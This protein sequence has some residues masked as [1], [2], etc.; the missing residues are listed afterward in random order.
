MLNTISSI[1][2]IQRKNPSQIL[3]K[4][5][6]Y[7]LN[8]EHPKTEYFAFTNKSPSLRSVDHQSTQSN[9]DHALDDN[10]QTRKIL[11]SS[12]TLSHITVIDDHHSTTKNEYPCSLTQMLLAYA[13]QD[14]EILTSLAPKRSDNSLNNIL[15]VLELH[16]NMYTN[17]K[18]EIYF[19]GIFQILHDFKEQITELT[20]IETMQLLQIDPFASCNFENFILILC[21]LPPIKQDPNNFFITFNELDYNK[22]LYITFEDIQYVLSHLTSRFDEEIIRAAIHTIDIDHDQDRLSY[23]DFVTN[24]TVPCSIPSF[25][26]SGVIVAGT[27]S[28]GS[29]P[30]QLNL[31]YGLYVGLNDSVYVGDVGN[32][33]IQLWL[34]GAIQGI[35]VAGGQGYGSNA[36]QLDGARDVYVDSAYNLIVLDT[37][38][39]RIQQYNLLSGSTIG[40]TIMSNLPLSCRNMFV[41]ST[42]GTIYLSDM[43]NHN[44]RRMPNGTILAGGNG[45]GSQSNQLYYP[46]GLFV[47]PTGTIYVADS[48]ND[49]VQMW[50][51]G[52]SIGIT[53]AGGNGRGSAANQLNSP[54]HVIYM[55]STGNLIVTDS[56]NGRIQIW[57]PNA[58]CGI[59]IVSNQFMYPMSSAL[60]L[61]GQNLYVLDQVRGQVKRFNLLSSN[62]LCIPA[63][64]SIIAPSTTTA[65]TMV[66]SSISSTVSGT[67]ALTT[68]QVDGV[69]PSWGIVVITVGTVGL[70]VIASF[71]YVLKAII[72]SQTKVE[73]FV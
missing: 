39:R 19:E 55:A 37:G 22:D 43:Y 3:F 18:Q 57:A 32:D 59:T 69:I 71:I 54:M 63:N 72:T 21:H 36:T 66:A 10:D 41:E 70:V 40:T 17:D 30:Q 12:S 9:S 46:A 15:N 48:F 28:T 11:N 26:P 60:D 56:G 13:Q 16:F 67:Q 34:S 14:I 7:Q 25:Y 38:N 45:F 20:L 58:T 52:A 35:T 2:N 68:E 49:R 47:T 4:N 62:S 27:S 73:P 5:S 31:P 53:V 1:G 23:F 65:S 51:S 24:S 61:M 8:I 44:V 50:T 29:Q 33:R 6:Q 42:T 64:C